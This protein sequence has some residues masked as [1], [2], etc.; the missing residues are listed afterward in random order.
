MFHYVEDKTKESKIGRKIK[1]LIYLENNFDAVK[2]NLLGGGGG[3]RS[4]N[5]LRSKFMKSGMLT[6]SHIAEKF[7]GF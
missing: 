5:G 4:S 2:A 7:N 6:I 1:T 3:C